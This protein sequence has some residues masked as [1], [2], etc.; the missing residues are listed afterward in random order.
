MEHR[1]SAH[2]H[3]VDLRSV[4]FPCVFGLGLLAASIS[5]CDRGKPS[6]GKA[7]WATLS[8]LAAKYDS[9]KGP[10]T[11]S[12]PDNSNYT[13]VYEYFFSPIKMDVTR[14]FEIGVAAGASLHMW[15]D[16]FPR[17]VVFGI[18]IKDTS[19]LNSDRIKTYVADQSDRKQLQAFVDAYGSN[20]DILIDDGGHTME[21]QQV[22]FGYLFKHVKSGGYYII[23]DVG[24]S[25]FKGRLAEM[26]GVK[27]DETNTTLTMLH[28]FTKTRRIES[29][30]MTPEERE[31]LTN[32]VRYFTFLDNLPM[33]IAYIFKKK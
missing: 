23:E 7:P 2:K 24:T 28:N 17:A 29:Q 27:E 5:G 3:E 32:N 26:Y 31:Y 1:D 20:F 19:H 12:A 4:A 6:E 11:A 15:S 8:Q 14:V 10:R 22:S 25:L 21:Q 30:Y 16:Y 9:D 13:E 18:D 33:S